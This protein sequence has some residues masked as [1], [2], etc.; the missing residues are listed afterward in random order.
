MLLDK[1]EEILLKCLHN[2]HILT[3]HII[4]QN[5]SRVNHF[6]IEGL[7]PKKKESDQDPNSNTEMLVA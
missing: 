2:T 6:V 4:I 5:V 7:N 3:D 1:L